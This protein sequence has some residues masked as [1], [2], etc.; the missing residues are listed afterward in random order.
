[1][2]LRLSKKYGVNPSVGI[3]FW[4]GEGKEVIL[5]GANRGK[6][7]PREVLVNYEPC[8]KCKNGM[9]KGITAIEAQ[10]TPLQDGQQPIQETPNGPTLWPTGRWF[11]LTEEAIIRMVQEPMAEQILKK[12]KMFMDK[13]TVEML[14]LAEIE[15]THQ[16]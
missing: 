5:F 9:S 1:M 7:A 15:P 8:D 16:L 6:E 4:C 13:D 14:G 10:E 12:R 3:C 2:N 11:V